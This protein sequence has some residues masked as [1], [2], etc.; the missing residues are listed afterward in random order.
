MRRT[1][2]TIAAVAVMMV[3]YGSTALGAD[4]GGANGELRFMGTQGCSLQFGV[5]GFQRG[6]SGT[7]DL[8]VM[9]FSSTFHFTTSSQ[10]QRQTVDLKKILKDHIPHPVLVQVSYHL[11]V[12]E[13]SISG[14]TV[15]ECICG[16]GGGG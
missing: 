14:S 11:T 7:L 16:Q 12:S 15:A 10:Q 4:S 13:T 5:Y 3:A 2:V 6:T 1:I 8:T 9:G